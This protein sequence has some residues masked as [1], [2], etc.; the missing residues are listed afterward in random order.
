MLVQK[1][2]TKDNFTYKFVVHFET[3]EYSK[4]IEYHYNHMCTHHSWQNQYIGV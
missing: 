1:S 3:A 2:T 4:G